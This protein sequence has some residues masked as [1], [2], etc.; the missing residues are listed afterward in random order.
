MLTRSIWRSENA[1]QQTEANASAPIS[2]SSRARLSCRRRSSSAST[3]SS[4]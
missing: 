4:T 2:A 3:G 1:V